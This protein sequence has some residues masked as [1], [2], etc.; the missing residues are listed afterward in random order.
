MRTAFTIMLILGSAGGIGSGYHFTIPH[1]FW[2]S[3][4]LLTLIALALL[5]MLQLRKWGSGAQAIR[6]VRSK[7]PHALHMSETEDLYG[8]SGRAVRPQ[9]ALG[10]L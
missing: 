4:G 7:Q 1:L 2:G 9:V 3:L 6:A 10:I 8:A 5:A